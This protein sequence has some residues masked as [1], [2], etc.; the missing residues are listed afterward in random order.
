M[1]W[2]TCSCYRVS[3]QSRRHVNKKSKWLTRTSKSMIGVK[4]TID[5]GFA[6]LYI[7]QDPKPRMKKCPWLCG[8]ADTA[9]LNSPAVACARLFRHS[10]H[11]LTTPNPF[12]IPDLTSSLLIENPS[13]SASSRPTVQF[14]T[15]F[16]QK[17]HHVAVPLP[18]PVLHQPCRR[19]NGPFSLGVGCLVRCSFDSQFNI[20]GSVEG[21]GDFAVCCHPSS[22]EQ[23]VHTYDFQIRLAITL[24]DRNGQPCQR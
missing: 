21:H 7:S 15:R 24:H 20:R 22:Y 4:I 10:L 12:A 18:G 1:Y 13:R 11:P 17:I 3:A 8:A 6:C 9:S 19:T 23:F 16:P 14:N 5:K 2:F